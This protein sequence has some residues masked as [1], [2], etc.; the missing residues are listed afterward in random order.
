MV[1]KYKRQGPNGTEI[2]VVISTSFGGGWSTGSRDSEFMAMD[3]GLV[4]LALSK[5]TEDQVKSYLENIEH[6][7]Y[8]CWEDME[9]VWVPE[10]TRFYIEEYDGSETVVIL[11]PDFGYVA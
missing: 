7:S 9:V 8:G 6:H 3:V 11:K 5:A 4:S 2:G 10:G 1:S